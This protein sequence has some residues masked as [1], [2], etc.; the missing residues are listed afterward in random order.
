M[1]IINER[2]PPESHPTSLKPAGWEPA[3]CEPHLTKDRSPSPTEFQPTG[4]SP[5]LD[6]VGSADRGRRGNATIK[7]PADGRSNRPGRVLRAPFG[8]ARTARAVK[9]SNGLRA[10]SREREQPRLPTQDP[11]SVRAVQSPEPSMLGASEMRTNASAAPGGL[12]ANR[13]SEAT[14]QQP[15]GESKGTDSMG[16]ILPANRWTPT[17]TPP[18]SRPERHVLAEACPVG[19][20]YVADP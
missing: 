17:P 12:P 16:V 8:V 1:G 14:V 5:R 3:R 2:S 15:E 19:G 9:V 18:Q 13:R 7:T 10:Y 20:G 11:R 6:T 4:H